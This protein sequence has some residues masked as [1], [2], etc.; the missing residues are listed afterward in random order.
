MVM[1]INSLSITC[2]LYIFVTPYRSVVAQDS[3]IFD[4][5]TFQ[6][7]ESLGSAFETRCGSSGDYPCYCN[8]DVDDQIECPYC[9]V[10]TSTPN[11]LRCAK[12]G[13]TIQVIDL[14]GRGQSCT[15]DASDPTDPQPVC[16]EDESALVCTFAMEDGTT[17]TRQPGEE[18]G[19]ES[20]CGDESNYPCICNPN[21]PMQIECP[22]CSFATTQ[23]DALLCVAEGETVSFVDV[24]G[25]GQNCTCELG[26]TPAFQ[27]SPS[28][29]SANVEEGEGCTYTVPSTGQVVTLAHLEVDRNV[30]RDGSVATC[31]CVDGTLDCDD[32]ADSPTPTDASPTP[33]PN[34]LPTPTAPTEEP[35]LQPVI[36]VS[37][38]GSGAVAEA[39]ASMSVVMTSL[40]VIT[41]W[42]G[43]F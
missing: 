20:R 43:N 6:R 21:L 11:L 19:F 8:P 4:F 32:P 22:Y 1:S 17:V 23:R 14:E 26:E 24:D 18:I 34:P 30:P 41:T 15:C 16:V 35:T 13:Q 10:A 37:T 39:M 12:D 9:G 36:E 27:A 29:E 7:G 38:D 28:C 33:R 5:G 40:I 42:A 3:C 2:F 31:Q 25:R